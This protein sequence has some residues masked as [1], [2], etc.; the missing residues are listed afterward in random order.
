MKAG[1]SLKI[2]LALGGGGAKGLAHIGVLRILEDHGLVPDL[3]AGTSMGALVGALYCVKDDASGVE[4]FALGFEKSDLSRYLSLRVSSSGLVSDRRVRE[5]LDE[6]F[7]VT[8]IED[9]DRPYFATAVDILS[10]EEVIFSRGP[11]AEAVMA[12]IS[13]PVVFPPCGLNG[14]YLAD[15]GLVDL[16]PVDI[17]KRNGA[18]FIIAVNVL[19]PPPP[20]AKGPAMRTLGR[21]PLLPR[22]LHA[23]VSRRS[24]SSGRQAAPNILEEL[25][26]AIEIMQVEMVASKLKN[27]AP[28][29]VVQVETTDFAMFEFDRP[30]EIIDRGKQTMR[31]QIGEVDRLIAARLEERGP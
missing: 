5:L 13:I 4:N 22:R 1:M 20:T 14:R 12:S 28:D 21:N 10:G 15:G 6:T 31:R 19:G 25:L 29:V 30:R 11:L 18:D 27:D 24:A 26:F 8:R 9:L 2:G 23:L 3:I 17:L 16:V 7:G